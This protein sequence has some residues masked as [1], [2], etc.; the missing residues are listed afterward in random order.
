MDWY[1]E[2]A[3]VGALI[4]KHLVLRGYEA[5]SEEKFG[6]VCAQL[7]ANFL[8]SAANQP[9]LPLDVCIVNFLKVL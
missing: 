9:E 6:W 1:E 4:A 7:A 3:T 2:I 5:E 8:T